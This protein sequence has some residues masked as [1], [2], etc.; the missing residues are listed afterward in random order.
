MAR[1]VHGID[2]HALPFHR[3]AF[4]QDGDAALALLVVG[5][6]GALGHLLVFPYRTGLAQ[7]LINQRGLAVVDMGDDGDVAD[8]HEQIRLGAAAAS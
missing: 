5:V 1:R 3:S 8:L 2:P 6:H 7:E 4:G